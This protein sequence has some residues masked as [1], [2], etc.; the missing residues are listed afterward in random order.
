MSYRMSYQMS[1]R[2]LRSLM[3]LL[4]LLVMRP[5]EALE[6]P[7][8]TN[9]ANRQTISL[10]GAWQ[11][12][13]DP[14]E[15]GYYNYRREPYDRKTQR[16]NS[17]FYSN[18][19]ATDKAE[20]VEY[21]FDKSPT[22]NV[23]GDWNSQSE[24]LFYYEGNV[25]LKRS[26]DFSPSQQ[27]GRTFIHFGAVSQR[28]EVYLNGTKLGVHDGGF[29]PFNFEVTSWLQPKGNFLVVKVD[30]IRR[31]EA[32]PTSSTDW[33]NYGGITRDVTLIEERKTFVEDHVLQLKPGTLQTLA[34]A[35]RLNGAA[36]GERVTVSIPELHLERVVSVDRAGLASY[37]IEAPG[38][39]LWSPARPKLYEVVVTLGAHALR[40]AIGFRSIAT[41][42]A[43]ILLNG[44][45]IFLRGISIHEENA[46]QGRRAY[47]EAD[48]LQAL[49]WAKELGCNYVRLAHYPHNEAMLR[50]ADRIGLMVWEEIPVY[51]TIAFSNPATLANASEQLAAMIRRDR[52]RASVIIWSVANETPPGAA[53]NAFLAHLIDQTR[54]QDPGRL[55]SAALETHQE[56]DVTVVSDPI[57][58]L[59]DIVAFNQYRGWYGGSLDDAPQARWEIRSDKPVLVS[60]FG[61][62][63]LQGLHGPREQRWTEEYQ[64]YLYQQNLAMLE[65]IPNLRGLSPWILADFRSPRRVLPGIQDG[66]NRKGL[67][68]NQGIKKQAF[69]TLQDFYRKI[70]A[71]GSQA[72]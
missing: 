59:L 45:P 58:E 10:N 55:V 54:R 53:R 13:V 41:R 48:A 19:H 42:G 8:L 15:A 32:V 64:A 4:A 46:L 60:E 38:L 23:P 71:R 24:K 28:A 22:L 33:W 56:G 63:A 51:W 61:G 62:G 16:S 2:I 37:E 47:S 25:W 17:A 18:H 50:L 11:A 1:Y 69:F 21:D 52:N 26:F 6:Q 27:G 39:S 5:C 72:E 44:Q 43:E 65:K 40:D 67:I 36:G 20:L 35:I 29:T 70:A 57:G 7:L 30:N 66:Y 12:I 34:G 31:A 14:Y 9:L 68:S 49:S 3:L